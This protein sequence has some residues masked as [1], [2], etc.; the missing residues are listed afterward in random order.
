M[1]NIIVFIDDAEYAMHH[2]A[3][4]RAGAG[5]SSPRTQWVLVA[6]PPRMTRHISKWVNHTARQK[7]RTKW[8]DGLFNEVKSQLQSPQDLIATELANGPLVE[9]TQDLLAKYPAARVVDARRPKF[10]NALDP[11]T[12]DQPDTGNSKWAISGSVTC[13]GLAMVLAAE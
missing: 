5:A 9:Q 12:A 1:D 3:P 13:L 2:I 4:M 7:W 8:A 10:G 6:C 11:L